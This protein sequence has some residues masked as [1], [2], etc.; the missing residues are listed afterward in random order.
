MLAV[1]AEAVTTA[2][3]EMTP[4]RAAVIAGKLERLGLVRSGMTGSPHEAAAAVAIVAVPVAPALVVPVGE[5]GEAHSCRP[6]VF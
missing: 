2:M 4:A 5:V 6:Y 1:A 3:A